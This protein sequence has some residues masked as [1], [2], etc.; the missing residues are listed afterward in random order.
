MNHTEFNSVDTQ[1]GNLNNTQDPR[2]LQLA[3][4]FSF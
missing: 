3:G 4:K 2:N 1:A